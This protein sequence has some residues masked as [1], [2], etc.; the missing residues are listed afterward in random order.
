MWSRNQS[1]EIMESIITRLNVFSYANS[2]A[3]GQ[4]SACLSVSV[5][6]FLPDCMSVCW[7]VGRTVCLSV[8]VLKYSA[9][10]LLQLLTVRTSHKLE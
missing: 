1:S 6:L 4:L 3:G 9:A 2:S 5:C 8:F 10:V 7:S